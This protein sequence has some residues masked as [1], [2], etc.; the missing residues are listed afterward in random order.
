MSE[1]VS[2]PNRWPTTL[3][4]KLT[5]IHLLTLEF[6]ALIGAICTLSLT[7]S[8]VL[9]SHGA[10]SYIFTLFDEFASNF[11]LVLIAI[12][13]LLAVAYVY[14]LGR[15]HDDCELMTGKRPHFVILLS[16]RYISP[17]LLLIVLIATVRQFTF[18][19]NYQVWTF[20]HFEPSQW[21]SWCVVFGA[22]L[23]ASCTIW[24]PLAMVLKVLKIDLLPAD[25]ADQRR[26]FPEDELR[27][28]H[29]LHEDEEPRQFS[30][31][32]RTLFGFNKDDD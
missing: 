2:V 23:I 32:E 7:I 5:L 25:E 29:G 18:K 28:Y 8:I 15:F 19:L 31:L 1:R 3:S 12:F 22:L 27:E 16:W 13:E 21:P 24:I 4:L 9:F 11:S 20:D 26:W 14:G 10:G 30:R 6:A 17:M